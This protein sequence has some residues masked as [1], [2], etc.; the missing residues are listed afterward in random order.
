MTYQLATVRTV[1]DLQGHSL[2]ARLFQCDFSVQLCSSWQDFSWYN[3][4]YGPSAV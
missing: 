3:A 2:T 4:S 1:S